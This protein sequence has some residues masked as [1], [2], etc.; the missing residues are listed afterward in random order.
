M[1]VAPILLKTIVLSP[2]CLVRPGETARPLLWEK[3]AWS[4]LEVRPW[5]RSLWS[6]SGVASLPV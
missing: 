5:W 4:R 1:T 6:I 2:W 3:L